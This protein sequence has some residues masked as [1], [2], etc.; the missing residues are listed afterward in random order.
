MVVKLPPT[1]TVD[2]DTARALTIKL[3]AG[4]Q[5]VASPVDASTAPMKL[6]A[7]PPMAVKEPPTYTV[8]PLTT[9]AATEP[10]APGFQADTVL[11]AWMYA[12]LE[13]GSPAT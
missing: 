1:K 12:R 5:E 6:R 10:L 11:S 13:R 9:I 8:P 4:F 7:C 3:A 2:P